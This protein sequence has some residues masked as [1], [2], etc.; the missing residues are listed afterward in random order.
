MRLDFRPF[1][2]ID[3]FTSDDYAVV[4]VYAHVHSF[5]IELQPRVGVLKFKCKLSTNGFRKIFCRGPEIEEI[6]HLVMFIKR[7]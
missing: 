4:T 5:E 6:L 1:F 7:F 2:H 3:N